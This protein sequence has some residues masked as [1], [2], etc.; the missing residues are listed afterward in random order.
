MRYNAYHHITIIPNN[1]PV[2]GLPD[3]RVK[4]IDN[5]KDRFGPTDARRRG[6]VRRVSF[7]F[8]R[9]ARRPKKG[10]LV[11]DS[12]PEFLDDFKGSGPCWWQTMCCV[13]CMR[14]GSEYCKSKQMSS[15]SKENCSTVE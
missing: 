15:I 9:A 4:R 11:G 5:S 2:P 10:P 13:L 12:L 3:R 8:C 6:P 1:E 14:P 7:S